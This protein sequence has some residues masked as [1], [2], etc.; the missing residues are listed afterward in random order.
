MIRMKERKKL[1]FILKGFSRVK[2]LV[3]GDIMMDRFVS[4]KVSRISPEAPVPVVIVEKEEF[5]LG[6]AA[7]VA[8]NI[9]SL[10]GVVS[11]CGILGKD[12]NGRK[13][14]KK[15]A[16]KEIQTHGIFFEPGRQTT[17]KTRIIAHHPHHQQLVR[18]DRE[19]TDHPKVSTSKVLLGF[20]TEGIND[21]DGIVI[22]D[23]GK[24]LLTRNLIQTIIK[25]AKK[26]K[27]FV[28]VDPKVK[29]FFFYKGATVITPNTQEA[30]EAS[31][32]SYTDQS[33]VE[34]MGKKLLKR[35]SCKALVIT[36]GEKGMTIFERHQKPYRVPT[37]AKEVYDVTGAGDTVIG[38]MAL[39]LGTGPRVNVKD[40]AS[41]ANYAAG[42]VV[43]KVGTAIV[44]RE[45]LLKVIR[46]KN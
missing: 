24:G 4:G 2:L 14:Y 37:V 32:T 15:I 8:H 22:S 46:E 38:T 7:N 40:A 41:L 1:E 5:N 17:V 42:V 13:L 12:E 44:N 18:V 30:S 25:R 35:L 6:G 11:L 9:R 16:E 26:S 29:N 33:S 43:G 10:G 20:L 36:Q 3:V 21:F 34:E 45:E 39:A 27:K 19:T 31:R 28:M 23:Y